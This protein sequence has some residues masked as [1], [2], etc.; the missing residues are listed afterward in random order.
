MADDSHSLASVSVTTLLAA[1]F[2]SV[3]G[4]SS[5]DKDGAKPKPML[6]S[7]YTSEMVGVISRSSRRK[8]VAR[9]WSWISLPLA[10]VVILAGSKLSLSTS[11]F[12][13]GTSGGGAKNNIRAAASFL[14]PPSALTE[15]VANNGCCTFSTV[16]G[17]P[18]EMLART[19]SRSSAEDTLSKSLSPGSCT[20]GGG[21]LR[22]IG[23]GGGGKLLDGIAGARRKMVL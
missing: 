2:S 14:E 15:E 6:R 12:G 9:I 8:W 5:L 3:T 4:S 18:L 22:M 21:G 10:L 17:R 11:E 13:S 19:L 16:V 23:G 7:W 20:G 1:S